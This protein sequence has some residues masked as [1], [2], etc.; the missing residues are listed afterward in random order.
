MLCSWTLNCRSVGSTIFV[1][2]PCKPVPTS[3]KTCKF[4]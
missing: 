4:A 3:Q 1:G 2:G